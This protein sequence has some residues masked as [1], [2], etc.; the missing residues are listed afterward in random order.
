MFSKL[1]YLMAALVFTAPLA[2]FVAGA[3]SP[4]ETGSP[5]AF[6]DEVDALLASPGGVR[7]VAQADEAEWEAAGADEE[8]PAP[9]QVLEFEFEADA[10]VYSDAVPELLDTE[11]FNRRVTLDFKN[12][13]IQNVIRLIAA[14]TGLNILLD[15]NEVVG[16]VTLSLDNVPLRDALDAILKVNKLAYIIEPGNIVRIVPESRVGRGIVETQT[17]VHGAQL[18]KC[19][20]CRRDVR[21]LPD[22][23]GNIRHNAET[24]TVIITDV[25]PNLLKISR[26]DQA[27]RPPRPPGDHPGPPGRYLEDFNRT[28]ALNSHCGNLRIRTRHDPN[29]HLDSAGCAGPPATP[30]SASPA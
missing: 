26:P 12:A 4:P 9:Q 11:I 14:R 19:R 3:A 15:P 2:G 17:I 5:A 1:R 27:D 22:N 8:T 13:D 25:P 16:R 20:R 6:A 30:A 28:L 7:V 18:A 10:P 29:I 21:A 23:H 24:Q